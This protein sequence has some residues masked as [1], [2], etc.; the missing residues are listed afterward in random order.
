MTL[1]VKTKLMLLAAVAIAG[2]VA[3]AVTSQIET[4]RVYTSASYARDITVPSIFVLN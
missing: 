1:S 3:L 4:R 2:I